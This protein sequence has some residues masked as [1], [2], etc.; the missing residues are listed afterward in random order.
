MG[1]QD[2]TNRKSSIDQARGFRNPFGVVDVPNPNDL[3]VIEF[4]AGVKLSGTSNDENAK[5]RT[6]PSDRNQY[7]SIEGNWSSRWNG[8]ADP[9]IPGDAANKWKHGQAE[10]R[11]EEDRIYLVFD[12]DSGARKG[13]IDAQREGTTRG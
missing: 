10:V 4:A 1:P 8:G 13:L 5:A 2:A 3:E 12:W 11:A 6:P 7:D 9:T